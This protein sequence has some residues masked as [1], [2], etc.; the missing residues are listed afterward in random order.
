MPAATEDYYAV[1]GVSR[2]DSQE[3]IKRAYRKQ[4]IKHHPDRNKG[5]KEAEQRFKL[6]NEAYQ[7]LSDPKRRTL[8]DKY[9]AD[10]RQVE[11]AQKAGF[12]PDQVWAGTGPGR[13]PDVGSY[14]WRQGPRDWHTHFGGVEGIDLEDLFGGIFDRFQTDSR[15]TSRRGRRRQ[16]GPARGQ[17]AQGQIQ[18]TMSEAYHGASKDISVQVQEV[19]R[20]CEGTGRVGR[21]TCSN[22]QG[23]GI[24]VRTRRITVK[25]PAGVREGSRIRLAGQGSPGIQ[26]QPAGDLFITI[27][28][29]PHPVF[30]LDGG[31][32]HV[33]LPVTPWE[34]A[35]GG[36]VEVP[37]PTGLVQMTVPAGSKSG[38]TL[39]LRG[40]GWP[41]RGGGR[42]DL[43]VHLV[44][45]VPPP[46]DDAAKR[47]Y[48]ELAKAS[49]VDVRQDLKAHAG[50]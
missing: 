26:G 11:A 46:A 5:N 39:R 24:L 17:D 4:A 49:H 8:Y 23:A 42:G 37:T 22:C 44:A 19:C 9:G 14:T 27:Q 16:V 10:W 34:M 13:G 18:L 12:D 35:L 20:Q 47:A 41:V 33:N 1:L 7:V 25:V 40:Q 29:Q 36:K 15:E 6:I 31:D 38:R 3:Q 32:L 50:L 2:G 21:R 43:Y 48:E 45:T 30:S 28:L